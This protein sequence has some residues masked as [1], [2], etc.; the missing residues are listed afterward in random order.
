M[1][2]PDRGWWT[3]SGC[4][5]SPVVLVTL[6][7]K[8]SFDVIFWTIES[9][10]IPQVASGLNVITATVAETTP[11]DKITLLQAIWP[12]YLKWVDYMNKKED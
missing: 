7:G 1:L 2:V 5:S 12:S 11:V 9:A 4:S 10:T 8:R 3:S 6:A